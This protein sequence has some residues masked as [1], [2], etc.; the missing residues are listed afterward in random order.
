[1]VQSIQKTGIKRFLPKTLFGRALLILMIPILILQLFT[2]FIFFDRHWSKMTGRFASSVA[3]EVA[4]VSRAI[5]DNRE[6]E[7]TKTIL[8]YA[9]TYL[10][11]DIGYSTP[12]ELEEP[13]KIEADGVWSAVVANILAYE[14][15]QKSIEDYM[16]DADFATKR[17]YVRVQIDDGVLMVS[18]PQNKLFSSSGYIFLLWVMGTSLVLMVVAI[19]FMRNQIRPIR[20]LAVAAERFGRGM[21]LLGFRPQGALE[22]RQASEAF[23]LMRKRIQRQISQRTEMLAGISHDLRTPIT[24]MKLQLAMM[25]SSPDIE[26]MRADLEEME[27]MLGGYLDFV[28][29]EGTEQPVT[30]DLRALLDK[31]VS[32]ATR[33]G[34]DVQVDM[35]GEVSLMLKELAFE[36]CLMNLIGNA[37]HYAEHVWV[38]AE[39]LEGKVLLVIEDDGPGIE[40]DQYDEVFKP[41]YRV[42][43]SRSSATGGVGLGLPIAMDIV[44]SHGGKIWLEQSSH[45]G[46]GVHIQLPV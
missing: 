1:M 39:P 28:R 45:G 8:D 40:P 27:K 21:E 33:H 41:F 46:L 2:A 32:N 4:L 26:A 13:G 43:S 37:L 38:R 19:V 15:E 44:H 20:R 42:D 35:K 3:G 9:R 7:V 31:V 30:V 23:L 17:V 14:L 11:M 16:I 6:P 18:L 34:G 36:R 5:A 10:S 29:G 12:S 25:E 22:V 24:R